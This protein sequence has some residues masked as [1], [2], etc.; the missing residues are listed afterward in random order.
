[1]DAAQFCAKCAQPLRQ[2]CPQCE[3][4]NPA[5]SRFCNQCG[6]ALQSTSPQPQPPT[7]PPA[8][9]G[10]GMLPSQTML[11]GR[12][13]IARRV[14]RGGMGAVYQA[15][16]TRIPGKTWAIKE[17][18]DAAITDPLEKQQARANFRQEALMLA[19]LDH[20]NLP[21]VTDHF[22]EGRKQYLVMDF[23]EG[24]TLVERLNREG[25]GPLPA[26]EVVNWAEQLCRVLEYLHDQNPPLVFRDLK[27]GNVMVTPDGTVKLIDFGIARV[28][29][30]GKATDTAYFGTAGYAPKEQ[31]G[32]G[33]T[34][35]R[36]D[37]YALGATLHHVLT[38]VDP[39]NTPFYFEDVR[40]LNKQAPAHLADAIMK[41]LADDPADRWQSVA[42]MRAALTQGAA[43]RPGSWPRIS[44]AAQPAAAAASAGQ[45]A[46]AQPAAA[47]AGSRL[48]FWYGLGLVILGAALDGAGW[49]LKL[50][51]FRSYVELPLAPLA[52]IPPLF[53]VLF[54]PWLGGSVGV[55]GFLAWG[56]LTGQLWPDW[57]GLALCS[58]A[59]GLIPGLMVKEARNW[60]AVIGAG[61]LASVVWALGVATVI[62]ATN[63]LWD[64]FW[65]FAQ[66]ELIAVLPPNLLL[67]PLFARWLVGP[68]RRWGLYWRE[69]H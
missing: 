29:K 32:K 61:I 46:V 50:D 69:F 38:G 9:T 36:S 31:Y 57:W 20:P 68:A 6:A 48:N 19:R 28:F 47:F 18:S 23:I 66:N 53:G 37:V 14:G 65:G 5:R 2:T 24:E 21:T 25:G 58:F 63:G 41:A 1:R 22:T 3:A 34:D 64:I 49:W 55:L 10:T 17:M 12:Y 43:P 13:I 39:G 8:A 11:S 30:P 59:L 40:R 33:Q 51:L 60:K 4:L 26:D 67:L 7:Y 56:A 54:G 35:A 62:S 27:P 52:F 16:D 42:E 45:A 44:Q 15:A